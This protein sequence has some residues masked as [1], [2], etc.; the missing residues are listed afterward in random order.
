[1]RYLKALFLLLVT[2]AASI[3]VVAR[4]IDLAALTCSPVRPGHDP[5]FIYLCRRL[6]NRAVRLYPLAV[7]GDE[8]R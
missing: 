6:R 2:S 1:M 7:A 5:I 3:A 4:Q 8:C